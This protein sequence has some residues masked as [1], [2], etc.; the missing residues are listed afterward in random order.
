MSTNLQKTAEQQRAWARYRT[1]MDERPELF[2]TSEELEIITD[3]EAVLTFC[4][5]SGQTFGVV[6]ESPYSMMVVDLVRNRKGNCFAYERLIPAQTGAIVS[7]PMYE[8]KFVLL[9]QFRH[10][11]RSEQLAFPRGF[12]E[13][14]LT[15]EQNLY[16]E[17]SEEIGAEVLSSIRL[18]SITPDSGISGT[19]AEV[20][21]CTV[22]CPQIKEGYEG[23]LQCL[24]LAPDELYAKI[25]AGEVTDGFT[26]AALTLYSSMYKPDETR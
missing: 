1:L 23:I 24:L 3:E 14:G 11:I 17:L 7:V 5:Q 25:V 19:R 20:Y 9:R 10:A 18:G 26:L 8:G 22:S 4:R 15:A 6:Y 21:F 12:G 13:A 16:K 2:A